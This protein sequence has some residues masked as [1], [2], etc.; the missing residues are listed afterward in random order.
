M[1]SI[2]WSLDL[3]TVVWLCFWAIRQDTP[4]PTSKQKEK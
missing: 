4:E 1:E 3:L 2:L